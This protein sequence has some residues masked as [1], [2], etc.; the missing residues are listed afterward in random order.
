MILRARLAHAPKR[1][2]PLAPKSLTPIDMIVHASLAVPHRRITPLMQLPSEAHAP[3]ALTPHPLPPHP[4]PPHAHTPNPKPLHAHTPHPRRPNPSHQ[5]HPATGRPKRL[6]RPPRW[7][8]RVRAHRPVQPRP[9]WLTLADKGGQE[10]HAQLHPPASVAPISFPPLVPFS[11]TRLPTHARPSLKPPAR[12]YG[13]H[14]PKAPIY[15]GPVG[16]GPDIDARAM[17]DGMPPLA[18]PTHK[19][20]WR[21]ANPIA[22]PLCVPPLRAPSAASIPPPP[23]PV[24]PVGR[25][26]VTGT[27]RKGMCDA[28]VHWR[29]AAGRC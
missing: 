7:R 17:A 10:P 21:W 12:L 25:G 22:S 4:S 19:G 29:R 3:D 28:W 6:T 15:V 13:A 5:Q 1:P 11:H 24:G 16:R 9:L 14:L 26:V 18:C 23:M 20:R 8:L 27:C 2:M